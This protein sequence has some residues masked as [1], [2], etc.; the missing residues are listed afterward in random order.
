MNE[1]YVVGVNDMKQP[2][3]ILAYTLAGHSASD[4]S[5]KITGN[6]HGEQ[7]EDKVRGPLNEGGLW[8]ERQGYHLPGAPISDWASSKGPTEGVTSAG[9]A[10]Y[11]AE[12]KLD[13]PSGWDVPLSFTFTN[14]SNPNG[15][16][17]SAPAFHVQLYVNGYQFGKYINNVGPQTSYPVPQGIFDYQGKS[18]PESSPYMESYANNYFFC[19]QV[20]TTL[21]LLCGASR[22]MVPKS[23]DWSSVSTVRS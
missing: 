6:L 18:I 16:G 11:A 15:A 3:G 22:Q 1:N 5:W 8:A 14:A 23:E 19:Y 4:I 12:L 21:P 2:R 9:I 7:Y 13:L 20:Q 10:F 17:N